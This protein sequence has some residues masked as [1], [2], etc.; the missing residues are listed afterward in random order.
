MNGIAL[1]LV[2]VLEA[3][4]NYNVSIP[5][6]WE[7]PTESDANACLQMAAKIRGT[8][9]DAFCEVRLSDKKSS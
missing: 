5:A 1:L 2:V 3:S 7:V 9:T 6:S 8:N 4:G